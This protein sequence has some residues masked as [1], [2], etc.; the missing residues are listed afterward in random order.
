V[1]SRGRAAAGSPREVPETY[2]RTYFR[3]IAAAS[4]IRTR[5]P[6]AQVR[7]SW[8]LVLF[9]RRDSHMLP[10]A[11]VVDAWPF[12][13]TVTDEVTLALAIEDGPFS[14]VRY[15]VDGQQRCGI[16]RWLWSDPA[17]TPKGSPSGTP[18]TASTP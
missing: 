16:E 4:G 7:G 6:G 11:D 3:L 18:T 14:E 1:R 2:F 17:P 13:A 5:N 12:E 15:L 9:G 10:V 8:A